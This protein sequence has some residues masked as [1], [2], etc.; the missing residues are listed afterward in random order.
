MKL[1]TVVDNMA[2]Q[3]KHTVRNA[4][5]YALLLGIIIGTQR[6]ML[7][8]AVSVASGVGLY[9]ALAGTACV[10]AALYV[11]GDIVHTTIR[12]SKRSAVLV[13]NCA[14]VAASS[15]FV[16][17]GG[18]IGT[19][20][21]TYILLRAGQRGS[22]IGSSIM[23]TSACS[24]CFAW[25]VHAATLGAYVPS[26]D[27]TVWELAFYGSV[28]FAITNLVVW[29]V[30][31]G[32]DRPYEFAATRVGAWVE[33]VLKLKAMRRYSRTTKGWDPHKTLSQSRDEAVIVFR[34]RWKTLLLQYSLVHVLS[35]SALL[36]CVRSL[37]VTSIGWQDSL[38]AFSL[39][40]ALVAV[41][42]LS[43]GV[44]V[45]E[46]G[47]VGILGSMG[48]DS[49]TALAVAVVWRVTSWLLPVVIG[50]VCWVLK[51]RVATEPHQLAAPSFVEV[52][53]EQ[54]TSL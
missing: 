24:A 53:Q 18:P 48:V 31:L 43:G 19:G 6:N 13:A 25:L 35:A 7:K 30:V 47:I 33:R 32:A 21:K 8:E 11:R 54:T 29:G 15:A 50:Y 52:P 37:G 46:A 3:S 44:G 14:N 16:V 27:N 5:A 26:R 4:S 40:S 41:S 51:D 49:S 45:A 36:C 42:P 38:I 9:W 28:L 20:A 34:A 2:V 23:L 22:A 12:N 10:L 17:G 1:C 39:V